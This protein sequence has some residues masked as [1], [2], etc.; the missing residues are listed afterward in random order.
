MRD[1]LAARWSSTANRTS[2]A[3]TCGSASRASINGRPHP[4]D[5]SPYMV[6]RF[7]TPLW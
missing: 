4:S 6:D 1:R 5:R 7:V 3:S 2:A